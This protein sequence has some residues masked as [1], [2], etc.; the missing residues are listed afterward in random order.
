MPMS[1]AEPGNK[2][3]KNCSAHLYLSDASNKSDTLPDVIH[4]K[5]SGI[6]LGRQ[7]AKVD[8]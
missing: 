3:D 5:E 4:L 2:C 6:I 8:V 1:V 7:S